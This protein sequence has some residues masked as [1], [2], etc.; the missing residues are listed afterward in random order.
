MY[1]VTIYQVF[2]EHDGCCNSAATFE[3]TRER[4]LSFMRRKHAPEQCNW[5]LVDKESGRAVSYVI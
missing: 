2:V 4:C 5:S 1:Q 3:G